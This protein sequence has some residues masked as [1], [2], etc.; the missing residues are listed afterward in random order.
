MVGAFEDI[1]ARQSAPELHNR[2]NNRQRQILNRLQMH[3]KIHR[4]T[5]RPKSNRPKQAQLK[6]PQSNK[7]PPSITQQLELNNESNKPSPSGQVHRHPAY[8]IS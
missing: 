6:S 8:Q 3:L 5:K 1:R 4:Q 7:V 2:L